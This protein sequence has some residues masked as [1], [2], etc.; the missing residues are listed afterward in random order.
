M[1]SAMEIKLKLWHGVN[2]ALLLSIATLLL[3]LIAVFLRHFLQRSATGLAPLYR[4]GPE[5]GYHGAVTSMLWFS[6][7]QTS[8]L[9]HGYLRYYL[10]VVIA[11]VIGM[12]C[13]VLP[14]EGRTSA[15]LLAD[16][17]GHE[18]II[19]GMIAVAAIALTRVESRFGAL[20]CLGV[21]GYGM[22][23]LYVFYGAPD[24]AKTQIIVES[25]SVVLFALLAAAM[26]GFK[27]L[28][29]VSV[30]RRD[31]AL[32]ALTGSLMG[33]LVYFTLATGQERSVSDFYR[34]YSLPL[35]HGRNVVN[36]IL[37]D[38]RA[39]DTLGEITVLA[40]AAFGAQALMRR[41]RA[42]K[43]RL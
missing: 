7:L 30:R 16:V 35:A 6:R 3:G 2:T 32:G 21:V 29:P 34:E 10:L 25:L 18:L 28:A 5:G 43:A 40:V 12:A 13:R 14:Y 27:S 17:R 37:V 19:V 8:F 1:G 31:A 9:Q 23:L 36:V 24:L 11:C 22:A 4:L 41:R 15:Y 33:L 26:P 38:F 39:L 20:A 42:R